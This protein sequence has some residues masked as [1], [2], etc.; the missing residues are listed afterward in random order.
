MPQSSYILFCH[1]TSLHSLFISPHHILCSSYLCWIPPTSSCV[2]SHITSSSVA[3]HLCHPVL[4][5][6][7]AIPCCISPMPSCVASHLCHAS[8]LC[9][10]VFISPMSS[11]VASHLPH[12]VLPP[13]YVILCSSSLHPVFILSCVASHLTS[14]SVHLTSLFYHI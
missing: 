8:R 12:P 13:I 11:C 6:S 3:S 7:Y 5:L 2:V 10:P 14:S 9:H 4:H 1:L